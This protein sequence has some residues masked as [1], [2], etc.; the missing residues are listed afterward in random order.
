MKYLMYMIEKKKKEQVHC[1]VRMKKGRE[2]PD[3]PED[4]G[5]SESLAASW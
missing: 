4:K 2:T 5:D 1:K 3:Q